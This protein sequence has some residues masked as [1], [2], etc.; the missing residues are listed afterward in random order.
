MRR[1]LR[2]APPGDAA[3]L[4]AELVERL[5]TLLAVGVPPTSAWT[6]VAEFSAHP[7]AAHVSATMG[8][9]TGVTEAV[10][11]VC[12]GRRGEPSAAALGAIWCVAESA[13]APLALALG[14]LA[15]ALRDNAETERE[16]EVALAGPRAT[17]RLVGWL[18]VAGLGLGALIGVD[19]VGA[20]THSAIGWVLLAVG[21]GLVGGGRL[22]TAALTR[23]AAPRAMFAGIRHELMAVALTGGLSIERARDLTDRAAARFGLAGASDAVEPILR[24]AERAGAPAAELLRSSGQHARRQERTDGRRAAARLGVRL[25]LPLGV[26]VLPSFMALGVAPVVLAIVSSTVGSM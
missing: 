21:A 6:Y 4:T 26:C 23:Q 25:M 17:G 22:W 2:R 5:A 8:G 7:I 18:P 15:S 20:L 12:A 1:R 14:E 24:L 11:A 3:D 9:G 13:G 16:V 10:G 19:P